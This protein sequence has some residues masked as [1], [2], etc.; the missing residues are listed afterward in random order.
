VKVLWRSTIVAAMAMTTAAPVI[1]VGT[2]V[3]RANSARMNPMID[4][5]EVLSLGKK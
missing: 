2:V 3:A 1:A 4:L 5:A